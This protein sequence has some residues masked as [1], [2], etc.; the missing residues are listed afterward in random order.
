MKPSS[1]S[2]CLPLVGEL[3]VALKLQVDSHTASVHSRRYDLSCL[4]TWPETAHTTCQ[5]HYGYCLHLT[6]DV[7]CVM[8]LL[9][10]RSRQNPLAGISVFQRRLYKVRYF[11]CCRTFSPNLECS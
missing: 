2:A 9:P 1:Y 4:Q 10:V 7:R 11:T 8:Q 3:R 5:I 6:G